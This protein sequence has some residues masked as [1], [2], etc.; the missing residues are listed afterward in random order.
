M[1]PEW[2]A[3]LRIRLSRRRSDCVKTFVS[4]FEAATYLGSYLGSYLVI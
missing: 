4:N 1:T 2:A 3:D